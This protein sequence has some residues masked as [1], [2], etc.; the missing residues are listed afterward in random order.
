MG[1]L[2]G[3]W[4]YLD[5]WMLLRIF[6]LFWEVGSGRQTAPELLPF[7]AWCTSPLF[8]VGPLLRCSQWPDVLVPRAEQTREIRWWRDTVGGLA[9]VVTGLALVSLVSVATGG[10]ATRGW[11]E[12][13]LVVFFLGPWGFY[14]TIA[15]AFQYLAALS[16]VNGIS[17]GPSFERPFFQPN[18][19]EFWARWNITATSVFREYFFYNRWGLRSFNPYLNT[20]VVFL[21]V[22]L[23]HGSNPYWISFGLLHAVYFST[24]LWFRSWSARRGIRGPAHL[25]TVVTYLCVC[26]AWYIPS[27]V[28]G[29]LNR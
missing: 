4:F 18:I 24:Y 14:W 6:V 26:M 27:K 3:P 21:A 19:A 2:R 7:A 25:G 9:M 15:G 20:L 29:L 16:R 8:L 23:W 5:M 22:G 17:V 13:F 28:V 11:T 12:K 1:S 10:T